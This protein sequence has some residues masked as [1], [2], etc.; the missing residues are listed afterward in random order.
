MRMASILSIMIVA[1]SAPA[2]ADDADLRKQVE[3]INSTYVE[4]FNKQDVASIAALYSTGGIFVN[5]FGPRTDI[6]QVVESTF[7]AGFN[8]MESKVDQVWPLGSDTALGMGQVQFTGKNQSGASIEAAVF[9]TATYV[10]E[11]GKWKVRMLTG[12]PKPPQPAK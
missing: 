2:F 1:L 10:R 5:Q 9:W 4:S 12:V 8:H 11:G 3:Q 7:K 6:A